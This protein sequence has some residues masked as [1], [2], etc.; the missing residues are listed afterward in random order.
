[1]QM[2]VIMILLTTKMKAMKIYQLKRRKNN[3]YKKQLKTIKAFFII[4]VITFNKSDINKNTSV[5]KIKMKILTS[6]KKNMIAIQSY[7][8]KMQMPRL[9]ILYSIVEIIV[10]LI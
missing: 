6:T 8:K 10:S 7:Q 1:M 9:L 5:Q 3:K 4:K 2:I